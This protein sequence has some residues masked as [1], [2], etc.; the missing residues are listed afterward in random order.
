MSVNVRSTIEDF[1]SYRRLAIV[2]VSREPRD[3][4]RA[5]FDELKQRGYDIVPVN[6]NIDE[7]GGQRC[8]A[9]VGDIE[10]RVDGA[11]LMT[12]AALNEAIV[13]DCAAAGVPRVWMYKSVGN[14]AVSPEAVEF[15][16]NNGIDVIEGEC[17]FM[18]LAGGSW[19]HGVH[20]FCRKLMGTY[21]T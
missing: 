3:F 7:V 8:Y 18:F 17:P 1:L 21:P 9:R 14:G 2:G 15:C 20:R 11:I 4:S 16:R 10:P 13:R 5:L 19:V 6:P 12:P